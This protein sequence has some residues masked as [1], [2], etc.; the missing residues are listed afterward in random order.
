MNNTVDGVGIR[1]EITASVY[2][3]SSLKNTIS[4]W[5]TLSQNDKYDILNDKNPIETRHSCNVT[6]TDLHE[7]MVR[8]LNPSDTSAAD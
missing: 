4:E 8:N 3:V 5:D 6:V 2:D 7:Y 1:G